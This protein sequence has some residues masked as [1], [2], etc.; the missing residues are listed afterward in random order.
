MR[1]LR[2]IAVIQ[3]FLIFTEIALDCLFLLVITEDILPEI[4]CVFATNLQGLSI[5]F[6]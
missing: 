4:C 2:N 3:D 6:I 1:I 5:V